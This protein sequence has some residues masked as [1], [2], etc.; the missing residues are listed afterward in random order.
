[1]GGTPAATATDVFTV[2]ATATGGTGDA[3]LT[4]TVVPGGTP[5]TLYLVGDTTTNLGTDGT[6][7]L[8]TAQSLVLLFRIVEPWLLQLE[9][10]Q[11]GDLHL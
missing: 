2:R 6:A 11:V 7:N 9:Q 8:P 3:T 10:P 5:T 1:L 4:I